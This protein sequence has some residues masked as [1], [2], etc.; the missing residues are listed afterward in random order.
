MR[1]DRKFPGAAPFVTPV[2]SPE[3]PAWQHGEM[4]MFFH[5]GV[6]TFTDGEWGNGKESERVF[7]PSALD[8]ANGPER[9]KPR[10]SSC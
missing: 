2:P 9:P 7:E 1:L 10:V 6:N 8:V 5:F 4:A 3:Q